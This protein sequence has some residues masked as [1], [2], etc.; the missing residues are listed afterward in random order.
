[1]Y[2]RRNSRFRYVLHKLMHDLKP[3]TTSPMTMYL[4]W[5]QSGYDLYSKYAQADQLT[6]WVRSNRR[7]CPDHINICTDHCRSL[8]VLVHRYHG[9]GIQCPAFGSYSITAGHS[10]ATDCPSSSILMEERHRLNWSHSRQNTEIEQIISKADK[11]DHIVSRT[12][13]S[14]PSRTYRTS[15]NGWMA[16]WNRFLNRCSTN[17][18]GSSPLQV[19]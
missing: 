9:S 5:G 2:L 15:R 14:V 1:M 13:W 10:R 8:L 6:F 16:W 18:E 19:S 3:I 12:V 17:I 4:R 11:K 7:Y